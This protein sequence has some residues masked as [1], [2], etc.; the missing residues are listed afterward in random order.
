MFNIG[1]RYFEA[2]GRERPPIIGVD[3]LYPLFAHEWMSKGIGTGSALEEAKLMET[4]QM[5]IDPDNTDK[6]VFTWCLLPLFGADVTAGGIDI[7]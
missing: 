7:R 4:F 6:F 1:D 3:T 5:V 2:A